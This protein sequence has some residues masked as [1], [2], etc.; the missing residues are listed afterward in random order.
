MVRK[1]ADDKMFRTGFSS[2]L[3]HYLALAMDS[4]YK[5]DLIMY[6]L[7]MY[8]SMWAILLWVMWYSRNQGEIQFIVKEN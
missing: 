6:D 5:Y 3:I 4:K 7:I 1:I 2:S 8:V